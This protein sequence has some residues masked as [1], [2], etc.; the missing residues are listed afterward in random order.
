MPSLR[1]GEENKIIIDEFVEIK[2]PVQGLC[3]DNYMDDKTY[4]Y[5]ILEWE[6]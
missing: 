1:F 5:D 6:L 2:D 4:P 3:A